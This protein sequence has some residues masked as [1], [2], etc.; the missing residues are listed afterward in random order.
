MYVEQIGK[1]LIE[2]VNGGGGDKHDCLG[3]LVNLSYLKYK[4]KVSS[5][6]QYK[7]PPVLLERSWWS[8]SIS[9]MTTFVECYCCK[10]M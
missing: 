1:A 10:V 3:N 8:L 4:E 7:I 2:I 9:V 5:N 6:I